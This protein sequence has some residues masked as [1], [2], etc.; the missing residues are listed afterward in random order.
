MRTNIIL[1]GSLA[2]MGL[3]AGCETIP[4]GAER[5]P[6]GTM[7]Y[8][9]QVEASEPGVKIEANGQFVGNTPCTLKIFGD[10]DGTFHDFGSYSYVVQAFPLHTNQLV[11]TR[12]FRTGHLLTPEDYIPRQIY[13]DMNQPPPANPPVVYGPGYPPPP[14]YYYPYYGPEIYFGPRVYFGPRFHRRW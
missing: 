12:I 3:L 5:G 7:A 2:A 11:Q 10:P 4:P 13:F 14:Y 6:D 1:A 9:V 8:N